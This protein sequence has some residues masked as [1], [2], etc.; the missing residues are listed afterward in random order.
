MCIRDRSNI[1]QAYKG[2]MCR[3]RLVQGVTADEFVNNFMKPYESLK[4]MKS[5]KMGEEEAKQL[6]IAN[7]DHPVYNSLKTNFTVQID[8]LTLHQFVAAIQ[9]H[10][11]KM[12]K[13]ALDMEDLERIYKQQLTK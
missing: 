12:D 1:A 10:Q 13:Q 6:F 9:K 3:A 4:L 11:I 7:I 2:E 8:N 5:L